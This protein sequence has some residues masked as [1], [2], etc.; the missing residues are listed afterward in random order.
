MR[1]GNRRFL[2]STRAGGVPEERLSLEAPRPAQSNA[3]K[4]LC[5]RELTGKELD[6]AVARL[7]ETPV[8]AQLEAAAEE[9]EEE[10]PAA[11]EAAPLENPT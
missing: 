2:P 3:C 9:E 7:R 6:D 1:R 4:Q 11:P 5:Q 10:A 8:Q